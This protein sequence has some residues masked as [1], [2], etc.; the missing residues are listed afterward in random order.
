ML[1]DG[2]AAL[3]TEAALGLYGEAGV[4][5]VTVAL[6][7][8]TLVMCE[9]APKSYA[10]QH[11][12]AVARVVIRPIAALSVLVYPLGRICTGIVNAF[13]KLLNIQGSA[14]PFVSEEELRLVLSGAAKSGQVDLGEQEM[15]QNVP[16]MGETPV[17]EIMSPRRVVGVDKS[18]ALS[19]L[20]VVPKNKYSRVR[21]TRPATTSS[22]SSARRAC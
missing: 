8:V 20:R 15:I 19:D 10:V 6:T 22:A 13:F 17:R 3:A 1:R 2:S 12:T 16:E 9:I 5:M 7:L 4:G 14:E 11:A 21:C 18:A